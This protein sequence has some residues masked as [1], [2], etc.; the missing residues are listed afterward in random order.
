VTDKR[1][2]EGIPLAPNAQYTG[3]LAF[4]AP[5]IDDGKRAWSLTVAP[6]LRDGANAPFDVTLAIVPQSS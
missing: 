2:F 6:A 1:L 4:S 3:W 5:R